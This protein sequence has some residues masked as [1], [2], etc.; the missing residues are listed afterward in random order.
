VTW[1]TNTEISSSRLYCE[2][3]LG[4]LEVKGATVPP[5]SASSRE[6]FWALRS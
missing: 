2:N 3:T 1:V 6:L 5:P 4:C